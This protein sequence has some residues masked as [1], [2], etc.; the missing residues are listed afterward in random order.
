MLLTELGAKELEL[1]K[2]LVP[3]AMRVGVLSN[4]TVPTASVML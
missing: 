1:M 2:E 3:H 4:P